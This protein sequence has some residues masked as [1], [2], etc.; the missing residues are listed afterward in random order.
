MVKKVM[1][2][3][4]LRPNKIFLIEEFKQRKLTFSFKTYSKWNSWRKI[5]LK[6]KNPFRSF[7]LD[8][9]AR[10]HRF[11]PPTGFARFNMFN[12]HFFDGA[13]AA[14]AFG[15]FLSSCPTPPVIVVDPPFG[16]RVS[17]L[18]A[19]LRHLSA[20]WLKARGLT[21]DAPEARAPQ[22][23]NGENGAA[24]VDAATKD[25]RGWRWV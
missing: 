11:L 4:G 12:A 20:A 13:E 10:F 2:V 25:Q 23:G 22:L 17:P 16:G 15:D 6:G 7:L 19:T 5:A 8:I 3:F 14:E 21:A 18:F 1:N 24:D 9:D